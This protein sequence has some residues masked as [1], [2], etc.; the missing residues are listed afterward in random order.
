MVAKWGGGGGGGG[1][2]TIIQVKTILIWQ[3]FLKEK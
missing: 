1:G 3:L 2:G